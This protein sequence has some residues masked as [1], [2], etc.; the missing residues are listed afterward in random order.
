MA[1]AFPRSRFFGFDN[2]APS[3]EAA[4]KAA[5]AAGVADRV[6]FEVAGA[7][8]YPGTGYDLVAYFDCLHDMGDPIAATT[9]AYKT[10]AP[11]GTVLLVEPMAGDTV[12][13]N[14]NPVGRVYSAASILVCTPNVMASGAKG[15]GTIATEAQLREVVQAG[16]FTRFRRATE[17][18]FN[19]VFEA[20]P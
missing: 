2:H 11:D 9:Y 8:D 1:V 20:K 13:E 17:T 10:L 15:L 5:V 14:I 7:S 4:R 3:I 12:E 19:R 18:P 6:I 16:G